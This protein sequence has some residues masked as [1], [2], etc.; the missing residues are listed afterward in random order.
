M[1]S[2]KHNTE[3]MVKQQQSLINTLIQVYPIASKNR[4]NILSFFKFPRVER[5]VTFNFSRFSIN[6]DF[7]KLSL[8]VLY[9][10]GYKR[11]KLGFCVVVVFVVLVFAEAVAVVEKKRKHE[12]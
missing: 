8:R 7:E 3:M 2:D 10:I 4:S 6:T 9:D 12:E 1:L 5:H 11:L